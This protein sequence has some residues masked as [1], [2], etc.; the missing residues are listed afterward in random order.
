MN[1]VE[2]SATL[3]TFL[4]A[5]FFPWPLTAFFAIGIAIFEPWVPFAVGVFIDLLYAS[6]YE[7]SLPI[8]TF[9][10]AGV[11]I[12]SFLIRSQLKTSLVGK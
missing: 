11:T 3:I 4:S 1:I 12:F 10:G 2:S 5:L 7:I 8:F 6:P 9:W